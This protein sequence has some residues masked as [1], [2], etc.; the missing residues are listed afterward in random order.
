MSD[1]KQDHP[2]KAEAVGVPYTPQVAE[3]HRVALMLAAVWKKSDPQSQPA[4]NVSPFLA[5]FADLARAVIA[6]RTTDPGAGLPD[7]TY[8]LVVADGAGTLE[9][10]AEP[11][12]APAL[13]AAAA[14]EPDDGVDFD[15]FAVAA[16]AARG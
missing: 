15:A 10:F 7:G 16:G 12:A 5:T 2:A 11:A 8:L 6:E 1:P 3:V 4:R 14:F 9:P 13:S